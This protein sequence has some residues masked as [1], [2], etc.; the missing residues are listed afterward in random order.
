MNIEPEQ[1]EDNS[2]ILHLSGRLDTSAAP[3]LE[4]KIIQWTN[5][6]IAITLDLAN[7]IYISSV[8]L[9]VLL[10]TKKIMNAKGGNFIIKNLTDPVRDVF[11]MTGFINIL[12]TE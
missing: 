4:R 1:L 2:L 10:Q 9:R 7:L 5:K 12:A 11:E 3:Q 8:G 6:V